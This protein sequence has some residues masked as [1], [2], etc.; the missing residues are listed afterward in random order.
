MANIKFTISDKPASITLKAKLAWLHLLQERKV[1]IRTKNGHWFVVNA[2]ADVNSGI[3]YSNDDDLIRWLESVT[4]DLMNKDK[5]GFLQQ[6]CP[7]VPELINE[8]VAAE[9]EKEINGIK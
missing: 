9:M 1:F 8:A 4:Q 3:A 2:D 5:I 6:F 7:A